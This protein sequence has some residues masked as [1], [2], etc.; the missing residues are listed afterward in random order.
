[1]IYQHNSST[2]FT[3]PTLDHP[4]GG[5]K[6]AENQSPP[7]FQSLYIS[8]VSLTLNTKS[9]RGSYGVYSY[10]SS[11]NVHLGVHARSPTKTNAHKR[12]ET[13]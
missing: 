5:K 1:M 6:H 7:T 12:H 11:Q 13:S 4:Q 8:V 2:K 3:W 9:S 10:L